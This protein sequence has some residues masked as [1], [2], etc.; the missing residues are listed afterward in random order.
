MQAQAS[1]LSKGVSFIPT[2]GSNCN[3]RE[4]IQMDVDDYH[5]K[6]KLAA[7]YEDRG[8]H[9]PLPFMIKSK[10]VPPLCTVP[11]PVKRIMD[12]DL[13]FSKSKFRLFTPAP[14]LNREESEALDFL[15]RD[16]RIIIKPADKGSTVVIQ[17]RNNY[18]W[19]GERQLSDKKYYQLITAPMFMETAALV[20]EVLQTLY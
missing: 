16:T 1:L 19:E 12:L 9:P 15:S 6:L 11:D 4:I 3:L 13:N 14:N 18:I 17:D 10:W 5:R 2:R 20:K 8:E 7:Y